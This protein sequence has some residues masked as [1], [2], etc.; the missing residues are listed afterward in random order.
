[1]QL[2]VELTDGW[3]SIGGVF[4]D[5]LKYYLRQNTISVGTKLYITGAELVGLENPSP[6]LEVS[7]FV[8][9]YYLD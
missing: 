6:P 8:V 1:M 9:I 3:Y 4:D 2:T 7:H 5:V